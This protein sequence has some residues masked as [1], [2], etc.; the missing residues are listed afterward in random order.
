MFL[1][2]T[3]ERRVVM[4]TVDKPVR[5]TGP[6]EPFR[7]G[8]R[9]ALVSEGYAPKPVEL[10][11]ALLSNLSG[12]LQVRG[13]G[14]DALSPRVIERFFEERRAC[15]TWL[16]T[17]RSL[18]PLLRHLSSVGAVVDDQF[19]E[20]AAGA[21]AELVEAYRC[22][23]ARQRGLAAGSIELYSAQVRRFVSALSRSGEVVLGELD[24][25]SI[26]GFVRR[27]AAR[28]SV[29]SAKT[30]VCALRS[31]LRFLHAAGMT[32]QPLAA[33]VSSV[34]D[35]SRASMPRHLN[36]DVVAGLI[37]SCDTATAMGRRDAAI[38]K[39]LARLGLRAG[40]VSALCL[41]DLNWRAGELVIAGKGRRVERLPL[42]PDVG[43]AIVAYLVDGRP[44]RHGRG[45]FLGVDAPHAQL[46]R[47]GVKSVVYHACDRAGLAR[48][49]PHR[50]RHTVATETLRAGASLT[51][52]A[53]LLRH[54]QLGTTAVYAKVDRSSLQRL[55]LPWP[56][57]GA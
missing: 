22:H 19:V 29:P 38:L 8:F 56:D 51:E 1:S 37:A 30:L 25:V 52:V 54:R 34:A 23:L 4:T 6:L 47:S 17:P 48:V 44:Q 24:A 28:L 35:R 32:Q 40:E 9:R 55:A 2:G 13:L 49:G 50:L 42:P 39:V 3:E 11:L 16:R 18:A 46:S 41:E 20:V 12:W 57:G 15:Y 53:Q 31:F 10:H 36:P 27:E 45:L 7:D 21:V 43:E 14:P 5:A 26:V 33:A